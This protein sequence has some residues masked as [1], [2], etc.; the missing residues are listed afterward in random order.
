[1]PF[2]RSLSRTKW[3]KALALI[4]KKSSF[5]EDGVLGHRKSKNGMKMELFSKHAPTVAF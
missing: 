4:N 5:N 3:A 1:M 2:E